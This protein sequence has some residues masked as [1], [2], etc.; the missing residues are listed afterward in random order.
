MS[1]SDDRAHG[2]MLATITAGLVEL[3]K[4]YHGKSPSRASTYTVNDTVV[5]MLKDGFTEIDKALIAEGNNSAVAGTRHTNRAT[6]EDE[7]S[8]VVEEA[9][10]RTV[11]AHLSAVHSD[12]DVA[13]E[14]FVLQP[15]S[16]A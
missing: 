9:T 13:V 12:P 11:I 16:G 5:S 2:A 14:L 10:G 7:F 15:R 6:G 4:R 8:T 1:G 3:H